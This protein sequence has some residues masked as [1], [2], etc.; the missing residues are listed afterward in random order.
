MNENITLK[1]ASRLA[2]AAATL[3]ISTVLA[4]GAAPAHATGTLCS[5]GPTPSLKIEDSGSGENAGGV[6]F[7]VVMSNT[8]CHYVK[9]HW[10]TQAMAPGPGSATA[11]ADYTTSSGDIVI[12]PGKTQGFGS[13]PLVADGKAEPK[14]TFLVKLSNPQGA[15]VSDGTG[16]MSILDLVGQ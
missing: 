6:G 14:E 8:A 11:G 3:A 10:A 9:I 7:R 2:I 1:R 12:A 16:I 4:V 5:P 13:V 15:T